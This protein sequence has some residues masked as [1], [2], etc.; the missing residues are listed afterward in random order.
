MFSWLTDPMTLAA[1]VIL[2]AV[3]FAAALPWLW[4]IDPKGFERATR[5]PSAILTVLG[6]L[7]AA[8]AGVAFFLS[9]RGDSA[10]LEAYGRYGYGAALHLQLLIDLFLLMPHALVLVWPKGGAVALAA[11]REGWRQPMFWLITLFA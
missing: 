2:A 4:A 1:G 7:L 6:G 8:G 5:S 9:Y 10:S 3:Q 11:Y